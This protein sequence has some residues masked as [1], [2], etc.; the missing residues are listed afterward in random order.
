MALKAAALSFI[1][2]DTK[3]FESEKSPRKIAYPRVAGTSR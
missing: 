2:L 3:S 1:D